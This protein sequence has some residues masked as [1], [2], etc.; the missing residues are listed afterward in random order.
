MYIF[1]LIQGS[2]LVHIA[3]EAVGAAHRHLLGA[4]PVAEAAHL[5][6]RTL[7]LLVSKLSD[8]NLTEFTRDQALGASLLLVYYEVS[9]FIDEQKGAT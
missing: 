3:V 4:G 8:D 6:S 2:E 7:K 1:P 9:L 5:H